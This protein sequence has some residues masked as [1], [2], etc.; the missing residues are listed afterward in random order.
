MKEGQNTSWKG[1]REP[2]LV[3]DGILRMQTV[4]GKRNTEINGERKI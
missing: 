4:I 2:G 1:K 3:D